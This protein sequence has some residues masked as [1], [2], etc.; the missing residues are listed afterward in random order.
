MSQQN[1]STVRAV[2][3]DLFVALAAVTLL[4][5]TPGNA[6]PDTCLAAPDSTPPEGS[7]WYFRTD[8]TTQRKCWYLAAQG[9]KTHRIARA[10]RDADAP[11]A[12]PSRSERKPEQSSA[13]PTQS[14]AANDTQG[15]I[16]RFIYGPKTAAAEPVAE[17]APQP[18]PETVAPAAGV[19]PWPA[20]ALQQSTAS[21]DGAATAPDAPVAAVS[22]SAVSDVR[23]NEPHDIAPAARRAAAS[24]A[25]RA[26]E[27][28][29][30][31]TPLQMLLL[32]VAALAIA[33][34]L[35]HTIVKLALARRRRVY[36][37]RRE[38]AWSMSQAHERVMPTFSESYRHDFEAP[39]I[40][41]DRYETAR[42]TDDTDRLRQLLQ[43][44]DRRATAA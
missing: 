14:P 8:R 11:T 39:P 1:R 40:A 33:G 24:T 10:A 5:A 43:S 16:Q 4:P 7:H 19:L 2:F 22:E 35:L 21:A 25:T 41:A 34:S 6:A 37:D 15:R 13:A 36:V 32:F 17:S 38:G 44:I 18:A 30:A 28:D 42:C 23:A 9:H 26:A 12:R 27:D 31:A 29:A 20:P 3:A